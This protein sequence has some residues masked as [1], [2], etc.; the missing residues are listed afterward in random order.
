[1]PTPGEAP[2]VEIKEPN[3]LV[4]HRRSD[5]ER[6]PKQEILA[7]TLEAVLDP[8]TIRQLR[9]TLM[10]DMRRQLVDIFDVQREKCLSE[11]AE[12]ARCGDRAEIRRGAH[13]LEGSSA[14]LGAVGLRTACEAIE[15]M[16]RS[17]DAE[18]TQAQVAELR[19]LASD[20]GH[21]LRQQLI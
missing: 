11:L 3:L 9:E 1:L 12:A 21:A 8:G 17:G 15:S 13:M 4:A 18:V 6:G 10:P 19:V 7:K 20:V 14:S 5:N 16:C 2:A